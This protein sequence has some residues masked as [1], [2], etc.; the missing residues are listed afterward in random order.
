MKKLA[1]N[2]LSRDSINLIFLLIIYALIAVS[3]FNFYG[4]KNVNDSH[5]YLD[6]AQKLRHGFYYESHNILYIGYSFFI[7]LVWTVFEW[8]SELNIII[9]QYLLGAL[10]M[11]SLYFTT[12]NIGGSKLSCSFAALLFIC[13]L[14]IASW[15]SYIL[16][17]SFYVS[18]TCITLYTLSRLRQSQ[19]YYD[20]LIAIV[21]CLWT[22]SCK[23]TGVALLGAIGAIILY[24]ILIK[25]E[26]KYLKTTLIMLLLSA[27]LILVNTMLSTFTVMRDYKTGEV[28][29]AVSTIPYRSDF[30]YLLLEPPSDLMILKDNYPPLV[31]IVYFILFNPIYWIKLLLIKQFFFFS[32]IRPYWSW[33]HNLFNVV[34]LLP[35]YFLFIKNL[36]RKKLNNRLRLLITIYIFIHAA[37]IGITTVDWDGRFLMPVL[38]VIFIICALVFTKNLPSSKPSP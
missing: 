10:A 24:N 29:Y 11:I 20:Y 12:K 33:P 17:E 18:M 1:S 2:I 35:V 27:F 30:K 25:L 31:R 23:P 3:I 22:I 6:Y 21:A 9:A 34:Y 14:E 5:R 13:F 28:I 38:P 8:G 19:H 32:H 7:F 26:D 16:C 37:S 15:S 4:I 36:I